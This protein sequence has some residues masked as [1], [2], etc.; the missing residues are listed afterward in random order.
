MPGPAVEH[1]EFA[2]VQSVA[3]SALHGRQTRVVSQM[4]AAPEQSAL[5]VQA[6]HTLVV[7]SHR[8]V[9]PTH[10]VALVVVHWTQRPARVP[11]VA[12]AGVGPVQSAALMVLHARQS[13]V[14]T[15]QMGV[16]PEQSVL[17]LHAAQRLLAALH[18]PVGATHAAALAAVHWTQRPVFVPDVAHTGVVPE[19]SVAPH[20]RHTRDAASQMGV[21]PEQSVLALHAAQRLVAVLHTPVGATHAAALAAVHRTQRPALAP[22]VAHAGVAPVQSVVL[23]ALQP[24][25]PR[26]TASQIG[27]PPPQSALVLQ[28]THRLVAG[29]HVVGERHAAVFVAVHVTQR[30]AL[31]PVVAHAGVVPVQSEAPHARHILEAASQMG[32]AL[33]HSAL[34]LQATHRLVALLHTGVGDRQSAM[35]AEVHRTQRPALVPVVAQAGVAPAQSVALS[36]LH[37][38]QTWVTASQR[39]V[40]PAHSALVL[41][42]THRLVALLH[43]GV[44]DR[45]S[46]MLAEVHRT[47]RPALVPVVA[48]AGVAPVQSVATVVLQGRHDRVAVSQTGLAPEQSALVLHPTQRLVAMLHTGVG[49]THAVALTVVHWT[50]RPALVPVV[51]HAGVVPVQSEAIVALQGRQLRLTVSQMGIAPEHWALDAQPH[52]GGVPTHESLAPVMLIEVGSRQTSVLP[53]PLPQTKRTARVA[54]KSGMLAR[55][56]AR[57]MK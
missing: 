30:P 42:A 28:P 12:H 31:V 18:T 53:W 6:T 57:S 16:G 45:Q 23:V 34:V 1:T 48:H 54:V 32:V 13:R 38:R 55:G 41:Q 49:A 46:A 21:A 50:Q 33:A 14:A 25:H 43:T 20:P 24:L 51:A 10:A 40:A 44:G 27:V 4:G 5:L 9:V 3:L 29:L 7:A 22:T 52:T 39:G 47:Q 11:E 35:L 8:G 36:G 17:V 56:A 26:V 2:P 15:L 37:A 19:Q